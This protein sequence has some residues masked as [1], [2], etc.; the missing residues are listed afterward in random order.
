MRA[1]FLLGLVLALLSG[2]LPARAQKAADTLR[3]SWRDAIPNLDPYYNQLRTGLVVAQQCW[4]TLVYQDP[5]TLQIKPQLATAW[6]FVDPV[7]IDFTLRAGVT[8]HNGDPFTATDVAYTVNAVVADP[9]VAVPSNYAFLQGAE[10]LDPLHVRLHL[11]RPFSAAL[12]Y[13]ATVLPIWPV[14]YRQHVGADG[15]ARAPVGTGPYKV[16]RVDGLQ[17]IELARWDGYFAG[18]KGRPAIGHILISEVADGATEI[19]DLLAGRADWIWQFPPD[20]LD[21]IGA[22]P[23]LQ[24]LRAESMRVGYLA[25][26]AAG[27]SGRDNPLTRPGVRQAIAQALDRATLARQ[28][29]GTTARVLNAPCY[30]TQFGCDAGSAHRWDFDGAAARQALATAGFPDGFS[31][32][33]VSFVLPEYGRAVHDALHAIGIEATVRQLPVGEAVAVQ[34]AGEAPLFLGSWGSYSINDVAA[35]LPQFFGGGPQDDAR[36]PRVQQLVEQGGEAAD[37]DERRAA[38]G[39]AIRRITEAAYWLPLNTYA[40]TYAFSRTLNFRA[41]PDELPRFYLAAWR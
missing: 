15:Y 22:H 21:P 6:V 38:Y 8:F 25:M 7:T 3:I 23:E 18:P 16:V 4:D 1:G 20:Q 19:A 28:V 9:H 14:A 26:D 24:V 13:L 30:P 5:D 40:T 11:R 32:T 39:E 2:A 29:A 34:E 27:R 31:T 36:D 41:F 10:V 33:V 17:A 12:D 37:P 35:I